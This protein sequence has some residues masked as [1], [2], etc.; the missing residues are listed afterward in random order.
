MFARIEVVTR[1][2]WVDVQAQSFLREVELVDPNLRKLIRWARWLQIFWLDLSLSRE[3]LLFG[4]QEILRDPV[5]KWMFSGNLL[6]SGAGKKGS[7]E[8]LL[9]TA[10]NR[11]GIFHGIEKRSRLGALDLPARSLYQAFQTVM[12]QSLSGGQILSGSLLVLEGPDLNPDNL[13]ILAKRFFADESLESW[14]LHTEKEVLDS[15]RFHPERIRREMHRDVLQNQQKFRANLF[16]SGEAASSALR[17]DQTAEHY[18]VLQRRRGYTVNFER[19]SHLERMLA[20][21]KTQELSAFEWEAYHRILDAIYLD[22]NSDRAF[23][24]VGPQGVVSEYKNFVEDTFFSTSEA[25]P[26]AWIL[27]RGNLKKAAVLKFDESEAIT[28]VIRQ[29]TRAMT[30]DPERATENLFTQAVLSSSVVSPGFLPLGVTYQLS[31][32]DVLD[33]VGTQDDRK[34]L[35]PRQILLASVE[36]AHLA[37]TGLGVPALGGLLHLESL[38]DET[39]WLSVESFGYTTLQGEAGIERDDVSVVEGD[40]LIYAPTFI[41]K[42]GALFGPTVDRAD[43]LLIKRFL[44]WLGDARRNQWIKA[45]VDPI[46]GSLAELFLNAAK[47]S[48]GAEF[49]LTKV[50]IKR[51]GPSGVDMISKRHTDAVFFWI[52]GEHRIAVEKSLQEA[53]IPFGFVGLATANQK[54]K[55]HSGTEGEIDLPLDVLNRVTSDYSVELSWQGPHSSREREFGSLMKEG[56]EILLRALSHPNLSSRE[57]IVRSLDHEVLGFSAM[58]PLHTV[59]TQ[60]D[61]AMSGPNDAGIAKFQASTFA[62]FVS[63]RG[64]QPS[65]YRVDPKLSGMRAVDEA[66]RNLLCVGAEFGA[67][68]SRVALAFSLCGSSD[69]EKSQDAG[70]ALA[71]E[72]AAQAASLLQIPFVAGSWIEPEGRKVSCP[73]LIQAIGR[74]PRLNHSRSADFKAASDQ[75]YLLGPQHFS[76]EGSRVGEWFG[77]PKEKAKLQPD[78][79]L[80]R[81]LY[82]WLGGTLGKEQRKLKS[83]HD[84]SDGGLL[85]A[86]AESSLAR[87]FGISLEIPQGLPDYVEWEFLFG[88]GFHSFVVTTSEVEAPMVEAEM[89]ALEIPY[90]KLGQV[91]ATGIFQVA[92]GEKPVFS[93]ETKVLRAAWRKEGYWE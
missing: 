27:E 5:S 50:P 71:S 52:S 38:T 84:V 29:S 24:V 63:A 18:Q 43:R 53:M 86:L 82:A 85:V 66:I 15:E 36:G 87:N 58:K 42:D 34:R 57:W 35:H 45:S 55:I 12:R 17:F 10:P 69:P 13:R 68:E 81:R 77:V 14:T 75:V 76:L 31:A 59:G 60:A 6:P 33:S 74:V 37:T 83:L 62:G 88:E 72:G 2:E 30:T 19:E 32:Q 1:P 44:V 65:L 89:K 80:A 25:N 41:G 39:P 73:L 21:S 20:V 54:I 28:W 23:R 90:L 79:D 7:I 40:L 67:E 8:D 49:D 47:Q 3:E 26:R 56:V 78:W 92:R 46:G 9:E 64:F 93:V 4:L 91:N 51:P 16:G 61:T 11:P 22:Q 48:K 70:W